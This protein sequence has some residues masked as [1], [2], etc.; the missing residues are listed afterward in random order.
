MSHHQYNHYA[1]GK[2]TSTQRQYD[3]SSMQSEREHRWGSNLGPGSSYGSSGASSSRAERSD[4]GIP[5]LLSQT[6]SYRSEQSRASMDDIDERAVEIQISRAREEAKGYGKHQPTDQGTRFTTTQRE[7]FHSTGREMHYPISSSSAPVQHRRSAVDSD[8]SAWPSG[9]KRPTSDNSEFYSSSAFKYAS[10]GDS[11]HNTRCEREGEMHSGAGSKDYEYAGRE[12][13]SVS[14]SES[15][16]PKFSPQS[17]TDILLFF[18]LEKEDL[19]EFKSYPEDQ[20]TPENLPFILRQMRIKKGKTAAGGQKNP[21]P[22]PRATSGSGLESHSM[23]SSTAASQKG[24]SSSGV[25]QSKVIDYGHVSRYTGGITDE[26]GR[27]GDSRHNESGSMLLRDPYSH[28]RDQQEPLQ[29]NRTEMKSAALGASHDQESSVTSQ[30]S[31]YRSALKSVVPQTR[32]LQPS[33]EVFSPYS[34]KK[35]TDVGILKSEASKLAP[36]KE[37]EANRPPTK[38]IQPTFKST[39]KGHGMSPTVTGVVLFD[40]K[41]R[42][43]KT[44][45]KSQVKVPTG[46]EQFKKQQAQEQ[47]QIQ[48]QA[49]EQLQNQHQPVDQQLKLLQQQQSNQ[50]GFHPGQATWLP[51]FSSS[52][53]VSHNPG[54]GASPALGNP[55]FTPRAPPVVIRPSALPQMMS[56]G[57]PNVKM[58]TGSRP[59]AEKVEACSSLPTLAMMYDY[60]ATSPKSFP[61]TCSL[62]KTECIRMKVSALCCHAAFYLLSLQSTLCTNWFVSFPGQGFSFSY[63]YFLLFLLKTNVILRRWYFYPFPSSS[64][65]TAK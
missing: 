15:S 3:H 26:V 32:Q 11:H 54:L 47:P 40:S 1:S 30:S 24:M 57:H 22:D 2:P 31:L 51:A 36:S 19:N 43:A 49:Q 35:N 63:F 41:N 21:Y 64:C 50:P 44:Q 4:R 7:E 5:S 6:V 13:P 45:N 17:A 14:I 27:T 42:D 59:S 65:D 28:G 56:F 62:C 18:G 29:K 9:Y 16:I 55:A 46:A 61:H 34:L 8:G 10:G 52:R 25:L 53:L 37:L 20:L 48:R 12:T 33:Q 23:S 58:G 39:S 38:T 60:A